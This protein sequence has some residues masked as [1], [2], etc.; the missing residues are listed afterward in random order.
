VN[1]PLAIRPATPDDAEA[2][3]WSMIEAQRGGQAP[4]H[5]ASEWDVAI[6]GT[7]DERRALLAAVACEGPIH[8]CHY[9]RFLVAERAGRF[10]G[11]VSA[12][13]PGIH[14][15]DHFGAAWRAV[16]AARGFSRAEAAQWIARIDPFLVVRV[17]VPEDAWRVEWVATD[18]DHRGAGVAACLVAAIY[19]S[20]CPAGAPV[21][22]VAGQEC[23]IYEG[24]R[25]VFSF[26][27]Q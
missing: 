13:V 6:P 18:P 1:D 23:R 7:Q 19:R 3:A 24:S 16:F 25:P 15:W 9:S 17:A 10:A 20:E 2:L 14:T 4:D 21:L 22:S 5:G 12:Y 27:D 11:A 8:P 26:R